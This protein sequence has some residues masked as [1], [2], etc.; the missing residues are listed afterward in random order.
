LLTAL[1]HEGPPFGEGVYRSGVHV[2]ATL[3]RIKG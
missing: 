3:S 2:A 1:I